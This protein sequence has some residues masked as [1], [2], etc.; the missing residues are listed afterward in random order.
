MFDYFW[1]VPTECKRV[2]DRMNR[3]AFNCVGAEVTSCVM[4][5][6]TSCGFVDEAHSRCIVVAFPVEHGFV[7]AHFVCFFVYFDEEF[8]CRLKL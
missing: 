3:R 6:V 2:Y 7:A 8:V 4:G 1:T 5:P